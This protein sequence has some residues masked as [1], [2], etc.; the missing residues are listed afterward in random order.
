MQVK[1]FDSIAKAKHLRDKKRGKLTWE[2]VKTMG[3]ADVLDQ[4][5]LL[6]HSVADDPALES[7]L[8][9]A[10]KLL[11]WTSERDE[12]WNDWSQVDASLAHFLFKLCYIR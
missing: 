4:E 8:L 5:W 10:K 2:H 9:A 12:H 3:E 6:I 7:F 1:Q 11:E